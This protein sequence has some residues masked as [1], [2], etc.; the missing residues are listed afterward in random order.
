MRSIN[1]ILLGMMGAVLLAAVGAA[2]WQATTTTGGE[3][4]PP[5]GRLSDLL[6]G[7]LPD[8]KIADIPLGPN[9]FVDATAKQKMDYDDVVNREYVTPHG[10]FSVY[11]GYWARGK[12]SP[13]HIAAHIP[14][15]CW[16]LAGMTC[17]ERK[18]DYQVALADLPLVE[19]YWRRFKQPNSIE[20]ETVF[21]HRVGEGF[22]DYGG[23]LHDYTSPADR[24]TVVIRDL[25]ARREDQY[26]IR[27]TTDRSFQDFREDS[28]FRAVM[29]KVA[30]LGLRKS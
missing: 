3:R 23:R 1:K 25:F 26:L 24:V 17:L 15:R 28:A 29:E 7:I 18:S 6:P 13:G 21:W 11:I 12:R 4:L 16:T 10:I 20:L 19:G 22:Y 8:I 9:E 5:A 27:I 30:L 14:D 2:F